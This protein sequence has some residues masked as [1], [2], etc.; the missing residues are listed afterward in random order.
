NCGRV[1]WCTRRRLRLMRWP[2]AAALRHTLNRGRG[3]RPSLHERYWGVMP[4]CSARRGFRWLR[5]NANGA[6]AVA[7]VGLGSWRLRLQPSTAL[8][9]LTSDCE[10]LPAER[11][12]TA[13]RTEHGGF[14]PRGGRLLRTSCEPAGCGPQR[15]LLRAR[16]CRLRESVLSSPALC[17]RGVHLFRRWKRRHGACQASSRR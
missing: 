16:D 5:K 9:L 10:T 6:R 3:A 1:A 13:A 15:S 7:D 17:A 2:T 8:L 4:A 11:R 14:S 12:A